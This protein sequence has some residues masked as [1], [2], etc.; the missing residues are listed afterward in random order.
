VH[1]LSLI[2]TRFL[3]ATNAVNGKAALQKENK[4]RQGA[5][6][7]ES[8]DFIFAHLGHLL[9]KNTSRKG[10]GEKGET[11]EAKGS[12]GKNSRGG[13]AKR[14]VIGREKTGVLLRS[15]RGLYELAH[16]T[17]RE[18][19]V[20]RAGP[21]KKRNGQEKFQSTLKS[22]SVLLRTATRCRG[23]FKWVSS[24]FS[25]PYRPSE[26]LR[27]ELAEKKPRNDGIKG[28]PGGR[29]CGQMT[30]SLLRRPLLWT[31]SGT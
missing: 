14:W 23:G 2:T 11:G 27:T 24:T 29:K 9:P 22:N 21:K 1:N 28:G 25:V 3:A 12:E 13:E 15:Y 5:E 18:K 17:K 6:T 31:Q 20:S 16:G 7:G 26:E 30:V 19:S 4:E 8:P 10:A